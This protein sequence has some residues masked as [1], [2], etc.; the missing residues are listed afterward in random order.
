[1]SIATL[2]D[3]TLPDA[4]S[5]PKVAYIEKPADVFGNSSIESRKF[6]VKPNLHDVSDIDGARPK[7]VRQRNYESKALYV[8]DID[9]ARAKFHDKFLHTKRHVD[10]L[11]PDYKLPSVTLAPYEPPKFI[12]N[13]MEIDDIEGTRTKQRKV[14]PSRDT[15][16]LD[17]IEGSRAGWK[18][19]H[20][21]VRS[22]A[23]AHDILVTT[24]NPKKK[25]FKDHTHRSTNPLAP[26]YSINGD[27]I[28]DDP[29]SKPAKPKKFIADN[30]LLRTDDVEGA[31]AGYVSQHLLSV[32]MDRRREFRNTNYLGDIP[33]A[34]ADSVKHSI[35]TLRETNPL[36]PVYKSLD[37]EPLK[38]PIDPLIP[39]ELV[40]NKAS[41]K[42]FGTSRDLI[43]VQNKRDSSS[44]SA[45]KRRAS[46][47]G[48]STG[49]PNDD[50][51]AFQPYG[52]GGETSQY[53]DTSFTESRSYADKFGSSDLIDTNNASSF[54]DDSNE[55]MPATKPPSHGKL[56]VDIP[57]SNSYAGETNI[58][59][60][61]SSRSGRS[62]GSRSNDA[63]RRTT[64]RSGQAT[65]KSSQG[66]PKSGRS[67]SISAR[68]AQA[69]LQAE[70]DAIRNL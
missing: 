40:D 15:M 17:D 7:G 50:E 59:T 64:P 44:A 61:M 41:Y 27:V 21:R 1:M 4:K 38:G 66:T 16:N 43:P 32:P 29:R 36:Q 57:R 48:A 39:P 70:V 69:E 49:V 53:F 18:P 5:K 47:G 52:S 2:G 19:R 14:A 28:E 55:L 60:G 30:K 10:P 42:T 11:Q 6:L 62:F 45:P 9:G 54:F 68:R 35:R 26:S 3:S 46:S 37:G 22:E 65:P 58:S 31:Q 67:P 8:D 24:E 23:P 20:M 33:G 51:Q 13:S 63:S 12:K 34:Q 56:Q 25:T